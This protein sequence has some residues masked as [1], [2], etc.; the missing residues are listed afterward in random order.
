MIIAIAVL[1]FTVWEILKLMRTDPDAFR[2]LSKSE[3]EL[4][5]KDLPTGLIILLVV[6]LVV[7]TLTEFGAFS[8]NPLIEVTLTAL[9]LLL[10]VYYFFQ[11]R[12][13]Q[14]SRNRMMRILGRNDDFGMTQY[15]QSRRR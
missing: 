7:I 3:K 8:F 6:A 4:S 15:S 11:K 13:L 1:L 9:V 12:K 14:K 10:L 2:A 5:L